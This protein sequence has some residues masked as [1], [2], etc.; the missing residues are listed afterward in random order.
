[1]VTPSRLPDI[2][3]PSPGAYIHWGIEQR[4]KGSLKAVACVKKYTGRTNWCVPSLSSADKGSHRGH[5][6]APACHTVN[7][8][9]VNSPSSK[10][11][12]HPFLQWQNKL[13][14]YPLLKNCGISLLLNP[15]TGELFWQK[16]PSSAC[17]PN[18][19]AG[20]INT[21][22]YVQ[23]KI[24]K[25]VYYAHRIIRAWVDGKTPARLLDHA[26]RN[27]SNNQPWNI[28]PCATVKIKQT[29]TLKKVTVST[30]K[31]KYQARIRFYKKRLYLGYFDTAE[32]AHNCYIEAKR[33]LFGE[34]AP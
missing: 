28:R 29:S 8:R 10:S 11:P 22:G 5:D 21:A 1:V 25:Q 9:H 15:L 33:R 3:P 17:R 32:E 23:L 26:D 34:F 19:L 13:Y 20:Y 16:S 2:E 14:P 30:L 27:K 12:P 18:G 7:R 24:K 31:N 4:V 6:V